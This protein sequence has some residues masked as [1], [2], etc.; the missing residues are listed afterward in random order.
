M[1]KALNR[2]E[3][4]LPLLALE[5]LDDKVQTTFSAED[6]SSMLKII[7]S[8]CRN[9]LNYFKLAASSQQCCRSGKSEHQQFLEIVVTLSEKLLS[10][11]NAKPAE[12]DALRCSGLLLIKLVL[13]FAFHRNFTL[14]F[15]DRNLLDS[16]IDADKSGNLETY[17]VPRQENASCLTLFF[18]ILYQLDNR[19]KEAAS[20]V[21]QILSEGS[22]KILPKLSKQIEAL[23]SSSRFNWAERAQNMQQIIDREVVRFAHDEKAS[24][25]KVDQTTSK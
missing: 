23:D 13:D 5:R 2:N 6:V 18:Y 7:N 20:S 3:D 22:S 15:Y 17:K 11:L 19:Y 9:H 16:I 10:Q 21:M 14:F 12:T 24:A 25:P 1:K 8:D 4:Y